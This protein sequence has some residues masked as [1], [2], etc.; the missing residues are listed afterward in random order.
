MLDPYSKKK[1]HLSVKTSTCSIDIH[2]IIAMEN[3]NNFLSVNSKFFFW[4][5]MFNKI[6]N[7]LICFWIW[8]FYVNNEK[9]QNNCLFSDF[10]KKKTFQ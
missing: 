8:I 9:L 3:W 7:V 2:S 1:S 6:A 4:F 5:L 10:Q